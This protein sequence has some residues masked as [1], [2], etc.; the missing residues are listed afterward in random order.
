MKDD[1]V[2]PPNTQQQVHQAPDARQTTL[3]GNAQPVSAP[4]PDV[5][6]APLKQEVKEPVENTNN[7]QV[8][9]DT[10][11]PPKK[12]GASKVAIFFAL[13]VLI[14]LSA[15]AVKIKMND[16]PETKQTQAPAPQA[17]T[18]APVQQNNNQEMDTSIKE[19]DALT[20]DKDT[21]GDGLTDQKLGL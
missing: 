19:I 14:A 16:Q 11:K 5:M 15:V 20:D 21:S 3:S 6:P 12:R 7:P 2:R 13:V 10:P 17:I 18:T 9:T 4:K 1:I 8:P